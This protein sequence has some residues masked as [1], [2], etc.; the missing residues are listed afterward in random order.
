LNLQFVAVVQPA[1]GT[2]LGKNISFAFHFSTGLLSA[3]ADAGLRPLIDRVFPL[4]Q[5]LEE[6]TYMPAHAQTGKIAFMV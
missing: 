2:T 4:D 5:A 3:L 1:E 6:Q